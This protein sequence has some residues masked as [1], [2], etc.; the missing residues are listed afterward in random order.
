M[1]RKGER[2]VR[3]PCGVKL[4]GMYRAAKEEAYGRRWNTPRLTQ[5]VV[6]LHV[7]PIGTFFMD[8]VK[9]LD[10]RVEKTFTIHER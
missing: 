2:D 9:L 1:A 8:T 3:G 7:E 5:G 6:N 10:F 4:S